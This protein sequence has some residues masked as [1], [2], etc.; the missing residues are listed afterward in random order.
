MAS[1]DVAIPCY[2]Y[3]RYLRACVESVLRQ[4]VD[5]L[6]VLI[7]DNA[8]TDDSVA[9][10]RELVEEDDRVLLLARE[11][12]MGPHSSF[13]GAIDW[14]TADYFTVLCADDQL[15]PGSLRRAIAIMEQHP[16]VG[17]AYGRAAGLRPDG[18]DAPLTDADAPFTVMTGKALLER[19]CR[20]AV[21]HIAGC[22]TLVRTS[23]QKQ[24]G[25]YRPSLPHTDDYE[26]WMRFACL[27]DAA[28]IDAVQG[29]MRMHETNQSAHVRKE[30]TFDLI[31]CRDAF[32]SFFAH[33]GRQL[34][35]GARLHRLARKSLAERAWWSAVSHLVRGHR[36]TARDLFGFAR[37]LRPITAYLPP[38]DY[39]LR[40]QDV[41]T[42]LA[43]IVRQPRGARLH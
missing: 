8:S 40:R 2:N 26:L 15:A 9:V 5:N 43:W 21:C 13:N 10:A 22:A 30:H 34:E 38:L 35:D 11:R 19:F 42:R 20:S 1:V 27:A 32:E 33:E 28:E 37:E 24:A 17:I 23:V 29:V 41:L 4:D 31:N 36:Q 6:R 3:G 12:N 39:L 25:H 16:N 7:I 18:I 14:A